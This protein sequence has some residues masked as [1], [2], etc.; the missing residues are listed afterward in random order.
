M[1]SIGVPAL[2]DQH[3]RAAQ[4]GDDR[5][6]A[7][8]VLG[9]E[10]QVR[11]GVTFE[12]VESQ[13]HD[14]RRVRIDLVHDRACPLECCGVVLDAGAH[15]QR[16]VVVEALPGSGAC[17][18]GVTGEIRKGPGRVG[19]QRDIQDVAPLPEDL[20]RP[21]AVVVVDVQ[22][23][24]PTG[25]LPNEVL[26]HDRGV[27]E[28]AVAAV[29]R[30]RGVVARRATQRV[31]ELLACEHEI[32]SRERDVNRRPRRPVRACHDGRG[33]IEAV[34]PQPGGPRRPGPAVAS[35]R[36]RPDQ[37]RIRD[38]GSGAI[39]RARRDRIGP[40]Q[41]EQLNKIAVVHR[42]DRSHPVVGWWKQP[43][44]ARISQRPL[45]RRYPLG[46]LEAEH[47][48]STHDL[49]QAVVGEVRR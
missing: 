21:V 31:G 32:R 49:D 28:K 11:D 34:R 45:D 40:Y 42:V 12:G 1:A 20:L 29:H 25:A 5:P 37:E 6:H 9:G 41:L 38:E 24:H 46:H 13:R 44:G 39:G 15:A 14:Q 30:P 48:T 36:Q 27:V 43:V 47:R 16:D 17:F 19:V 3:G 18:V 23:R 4:R 26:G 33:G 22:D 2:L 35:G 7:G 8:V 10:S